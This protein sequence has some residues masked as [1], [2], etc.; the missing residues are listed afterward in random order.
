MAKDLNVLGISYAKRVL[1]E[2]SRECERMQL[3]ATAVSKYTLIVFT[4]KKDNLAEKYTSGNFTVYGTHAYTRV[5]M[6]YAAYRIG[7]KIVKESRQ[8]QWIVSSQDPFETSIVGRALALMTNAVHHVQLHGDPFSHNGWKS[9]SLSNKIRSVY[10]N[11]V[12]HRASAVRVVSKRAKESLVALGVPI[13]KIT[14]LPINQDLRAY[15]AVGVGRTYPIATTCTFLYVGRLSPEKN[16][17]VIIRVFSVV[18]S[19]NKNVRLRIVG[20]GPLHY[21]L[22][23]LIQELQITKV[24]SIVPW[25]HDVASEMEQ[26]DVLVLASSH[27]GYG[28]VLIEAMAA[29]LPIVTTNVGCAGEVVHDG[30]HGFVVPVGDTD[31]FAD[32]LQLLAGDAALRASFGLAAVHDVQS[33]HISPEAY[34]AA[35]ADVFVQ[36]VRA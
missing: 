25:A 1:Q 24:V 11:Y 35:W 29:G 3:Y 5:G 10:G 7:R 16:I 28:L 17:D 8:T 34:A 6:L 12:L 27:E 33:I 36:T 13:E 21:S 19:K 30:V 18:Y 22:Q 23:E 15:L 32:K 9:E 14:I 26:A 2:G 31:A 20:E 4:R